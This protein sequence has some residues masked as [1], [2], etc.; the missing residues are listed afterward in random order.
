MSSGR[1]VIASVLLSFLL[2]AYFYFDAS[3]TPKVGPEPEHVVTFLPDEVK[4]V[5][6]TKPGKEIVTVEKREGAWWLT[7]PLEAQA[8]STAIDKLINGA[9]SLSLSKNIGIV[10]DRKSFGL[11]EP[12]TVAFSM[13][14]GS[15]IKISIGSENL[16]GINKY[17][18][19]GDEVFLVRKMGVTALLATHFDLREKKLVHLNGEDVTRLEIKREEY[20]VVLVRKKG[21]GWMIEKPLKARADKRKVNNLLNSFTKLE[22]KG[23]ITETDTDVGLY[24]LNEPVAKISFGNEERKVSLLIGGKTES[25]GRYAKLESQEN[26]VRIA[27]GFLESLPATVTSFRD[28]KL[29][30][31]DIDDVTSV[32]VV[33][34]A[35]KI[36]L[37]SDSGAQEKKWRMISPV[38]ASGDG[39][40]VSTLLYE[41]DR[42][43]G[44]DVAPDEKDRLKFPSLK[45]MVSLTSGTKKTVSFS[46]LEDGRVVATADDAMTALFID[47]SYYSKLPKTAFE[48]RD[49]RLFPF[50]SDQVGRIVVKR[51]DQ[52]FDA[53][54]DDGGYRLK[55]PG[56]RALQAIHWNRLLWTVTGM[57][58]AEEF[59]ENDKE[60]KT[61]TL[62]GAVSVYNVGGQKIKE[63]TVTR[64]TLGDVTKYRVSGGSE[65]TRYGVDDGFFEEELSLALENLIS[66]DND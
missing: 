53:V 12:A 62:W 55:S 6:I 22:A 24:G 27:P 16:T 5:T 28:L 10:D 36:S 29:V 42:I 51:F 1:L 45:I 18:A 9:L 19:T 54:R 64:Y 15:S 32:K 23:F 65:K 57:K 61:G 44:T 17:V 60:K 59:S 21:S 47:P 37:E 33:S 4:A 66:R 31:I 46:P 48:F 41:L 49:R 25:G 43:D 30:D 20:T 50:R 63:L 3:D 38:D 26:V 8:D 52:I 34:A 7:A 58:Y 11:A 56:K 39:L 2:G 35:E 40:S 13:L 14:N